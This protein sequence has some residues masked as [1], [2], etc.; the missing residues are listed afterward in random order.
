MDGTLY[1][2]AGCKRLSIIHGQDPESAGQGGK[3]LGANHAQRAVSSATRILAMGLCISFDGT[4]HAYT[5]SP[6]RL[7]KQYGYYR[8][9]A[10]GGLHYN[11]LLT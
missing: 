1:P 9:K 3:F 7:H 11:V 10:I 2:L 4:C 6:I 8:S 5:I